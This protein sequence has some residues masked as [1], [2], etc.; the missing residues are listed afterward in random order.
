MA[1]TTV[2]DLLSRQP[3]A[4][5]S[6]RELE[7]SSIEM[8]TGTT[9][10]TC[11]GVT[12]HD[13]LLSHAISSSP[14][15]SRPGRGPPSASAIIVPPQPPPGPPLLLLLLLHHH[16]LLPLPTRARSIAVRAIPT[17]SASCS[18]P[19]PC[20]LEGP[21]L[22]TEVD[23]ERKYVHGQRATCHR[24]D[25][26]RGREDPLRRR[27]RRRSLLC[28]QAPC[29]VLQ[30][31][32]E[33]LVA[34]T[35]RVRRLNSVG[36]WPPRP[37]PRPPESRLPV[38]LQLRHHLRLHDRE[39][40][41]KGERAAGAARASPAPTEALPLAAGNQAL[42]S[43]TAGIGPNGAGRFSIHAVAMGLYSLDRKWRLRQLLWAAGREIFGDVR[44]RREEMRHR[45]APVSGRARSRRGT[46]TCRPRCG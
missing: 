21:Q 23:A 14:P 1:V 27:R 10:N 19:P 28:E 33:T 38:L 12:S 16:H 26:A 25:E 18:P 46:T 35:R 5:L 13:G 43:P 4:A 8:K 30:Q 22:G 42:R 2:A 7:R 15:P 17:Q 44:G 40:G 32:K 3:L 37:A 41:S 24:C 29:A 6:P 11:H 36:A 34:P 39:R 9:T 20:G 45:P 31:R